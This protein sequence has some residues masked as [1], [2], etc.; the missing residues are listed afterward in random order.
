MV[1][2]K[3]V[4]LVVINLIAFIPM[5]AVNGLAGSTTFLNGVTSGEVSDIYPTLITP[6]GFTFAIWGVIYT[7]LLIFTI[8]QAMPKNRDKPFLKQISLLFALSSIWNIYGF[9]FG[10]SN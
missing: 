4:F 9:S 1:S 5:I 10:I 3:P 8:Y 7:L 2:K 6:A